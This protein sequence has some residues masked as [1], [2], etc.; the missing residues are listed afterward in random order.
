MKNLDKFKKTKQNLI[1]YCL[2]LAGLLQALTSGAQTNLVVN[3]G[4]ETG[5][6]A[7]WS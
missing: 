5:N 1:R 2:L 3:G 7:G 6:F 4:F